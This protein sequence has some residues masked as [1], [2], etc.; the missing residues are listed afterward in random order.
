MDARWVAEILRHEGKH[1]VESFGIER[2]CRRIV[3]I[4]HGRNVERTG[5]DKI[6]ALRAK[7]M[8]TPFD[9]R[10]ASGIYARNQVVVVF[11]CGTPIDIRR[12]CRAIA[13]A[14]QNVFVF[15]YL[16]EICNDY[17]VVCNGLKS[18]IFCITVQAYKSSDDML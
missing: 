5:N 18:Y 8:D 7:A 2:G 16:P 1:G 15:H 11:L 14:R 6:E 9:M 4:N 12:A 17:L 10:N 3:G 13:Y